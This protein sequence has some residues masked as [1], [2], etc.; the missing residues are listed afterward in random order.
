MRR[1]FQIAGIFLAFALFTF[2]A[3]VCPAQDENIIVGGYGN[4]STTDVQVVK[5]ANF[6]V[7]AQKK[8]SL[9]LVS[10]LQA[11]QQ[12]VAGLNYRM[13]LSLL[14]GGKP[15]QASTT[16]YLSL[17][18]KYSLSEWK[19]EKCGTETINENSPDAIVKNLYA[20]HKAE[21][22]PFFQ[23]NDRSLVDKYFAKDFADL[24]WK[25]AI[26]SD[27]EVGALEFDP[28][29]NAQDTQ[30]TA[31]VIG[32]PEYDKE[33]GVATVL[34]SYKNFGKSET[35]RYLLKQDA[36]KNWKIM[37]LVYTNGDMLKGYLFN[38]LQQ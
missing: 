13:C 25:D 16:V 10:I 23:T 9:K 37:D 22:S 14:S 29:Y 26:A 19:L 6:A 24:I 7:A 11:E 5:A 21:K 2:G 18:N 36:S 35:V 12:V 15:Q 8:K 30:I 32:K 4:A 3:A 1:N 28:L 31:F 38:A 33:S 20:A 17:Q 27:G 34:V